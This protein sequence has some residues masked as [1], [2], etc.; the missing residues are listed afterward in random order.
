MELRPDWPVAVAELGGN[1][2]VDYLECQAQLVLVCVPIFRQAN[3]LICRLVE[4]QLLIY[5]F[6]MLIRNICIHK[7]FGTNSLETKFSSR[8]QDDIATPTNYVA[9]RYAPIFKHI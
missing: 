1:A 7:I 4:F 9:K 3:N 6:R 8:G 5:N 2:N